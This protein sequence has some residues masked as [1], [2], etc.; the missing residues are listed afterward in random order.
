[1]NK[2]IWK[3]S[4]WL[5]IANI[6]IKIV[7]FFYNIFL[8]QS[9]GVDNFGIYVVALSYF[10]LISA[11]ADLGISRFLIREA[12]T[13]EKNLN[14]YLPAAIVTR[15]VILIIL[16]VVFSVGL[17]TLDPDINR[18]LVSVLALLAV[19]PQ[20]ISL[21]L[22]ASLIA[23]FKAKY[24]SIGFLFLSFFTTLAGVWF[25]SSGF[26][27]YGAALALLVG[28]FFYA[29]ILVLLLNSQKISWLN[30][31]SW[32]TVKILL[33][34]SLPY[35]I[36]GILGLL[37]FR[38]DTILLSYLRGNF[39][40]GIYGAAYKFLEAIVFIPGTLAAM[41]FP[42]LAKLQVEDLSKI[43]KIYLKNTLVMGVVGIIFALGFILV[44]PI[45]ITLL[46]PSYV[47]SID[48]VKILALAIPFMFLHV[49]AAQVLLSSEK[50]LKPI[51]LFS[52]IPL[53]FN[54]LLNLALI[55]VFG[56]TAAAWV[57]VFSDILSAVILFTFIQFV[58][59]KKN[60]V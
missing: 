20:G 38:V 32:K 39:E 10:S 35:G 22:D 14:Q 46:L 52:I 6:F 16:F 55:P 3:N 18:S 51:M 2:L 26:G 23:S 49:P 28:Q 44:L 15:S 8:A 42:V 31:F 59:F 11:V 25:I 40:A 27:V 17:Y 34:G 13:D 41:M 33:S 21:T 9:L 7:A 53:S 56:Y 60:N 12:Q 50:Y 1:M 43:K 24:S 37:Y 30:G 29:L 54:V 4:A 36:L 19:L 47:L 58:F 5:W 45:V 48:T 57:T